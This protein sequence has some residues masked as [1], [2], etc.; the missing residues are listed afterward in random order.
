MGIF[1]EHKYTDLK[2]F[3]S[4]YIHSEEEGTYISCLDM[5]NRITENGGIP[6][7]AHINTSDFLG[8]NLYKRSLFGFSGLKILGL[9]NIDSKERISNRIKNIKK[10]QK[11][12]F[13]LY[14]KGTRMNLIN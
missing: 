4:K 8:T 1:D 12:I 11:A 10:V 14:M 13:V 9:T 7:I 2:N 3:V 6:Y 5:V